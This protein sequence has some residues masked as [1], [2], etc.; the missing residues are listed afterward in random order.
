M[1]AWVDISTDRIFVQFGE[2]YIEQKLNVKPSVIL[3][4][5]GEQLLI[6]CDVGICTFNLVTKKSETVA[7][8]PADHCLETYRSNDGCRVES[9]EIYLGVMRRQLAAEN[10]GK[11]YYFSRNLEATPIEFDLAIPNLFVPL[12]S[13][14]ILIADSLRG[15]I[16]ECQFD[17]DRLRRPPTNWIKSGVGKIIPDGGCALP[18]GSIVVAGWDSAALFRFDGDG[19]L[20]ETIDVP[21]RRPTNCKFDHMTHSLY[22]TTA[23]QGVERDSAGYTESG[24]TYRYSVTRQGG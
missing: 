15:L 21:C 3:G 14:L 19:E 1:V 4:R 24:H 13:G 8:F 22:V 10:S 17:K 2:N 12:G 16:F 20:L 23:N 5:R 9:G 11:L 7:E 6:G 18:D